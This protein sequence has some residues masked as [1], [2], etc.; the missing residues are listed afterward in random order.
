[1]ATC[2]LGLSLLRDPSAWRG[3]RLDRL[4]GWVGVEVHEL[5]GCLL[6]VF[7]LRNTF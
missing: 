1:M 2:F 4:G 6:A 3:R 5:L 7:F